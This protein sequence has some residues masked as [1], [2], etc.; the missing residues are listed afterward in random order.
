M[1][2]SIIEINPG[3]TTPFDITEGDKIKVPRHPCYRAY[4]Y[5]DTKLLLPIRMGIFDWDNLP[6]EDIEYKKINFK[7]KLKGIDFSPGNEDYN[8]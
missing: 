2:Y 3:I 1:A 8:F 7:A 6:F 5:I 4:I